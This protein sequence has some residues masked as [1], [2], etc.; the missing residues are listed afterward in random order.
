MAWLRTFSLLLVGQDPGASVGQDPSANAVEALSPEAI[1][2]VKDLETLNQSIETFCTDI[3]G[4]LRP[5]TV[6]QMS[7]RLPN[8]HAD[9][10]RQRGFFLLLDLINSNLDES[11]FRPFH[12]CV[13]TLLSEHYERVEGVRKSVITQVE[14]RN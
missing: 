11:I 1:S 4:W 14:A 2:A 9:D 5:E 8:L 7:D 13:C 3:I 10:A 12:P 6:P